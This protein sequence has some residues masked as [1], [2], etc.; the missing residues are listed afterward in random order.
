ML[1][2]IGIK[3]YLYVIRKHIVK[4]NYFKRYLQVL[5]IS[6]TEQKNKM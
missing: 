1:N 2:W 6:K 4:V 5:Q 3:I